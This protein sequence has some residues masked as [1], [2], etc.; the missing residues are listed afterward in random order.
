MATVLDEAA[1]IETRDLAL[2]DLQA[3]LHRARKEH[4]KAT[5][6]TLAAISLL[7]ADA[8]DDDAKGKAE[9]FCAIGEDW[10]AQGDKEKAFDYAQEALRLVSGLERARKL[11]EAS[12]S[13]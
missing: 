5:E 1:A 12:R 8:K 13:K 3:S 9:R 6:R 4:S 10:L 2:L 11:Y 7:E